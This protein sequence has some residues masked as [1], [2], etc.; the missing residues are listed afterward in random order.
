MVKNKI[1]LVPIFSE[2][3][4]GSSTDIRRFAQNSLNLEI[5]CWLREGGYVWLKATRL[6]LS[7]YIS[8]N[9]QQDIETEHA[10]S[11]KLP[12]KA[13]G[14]GKCEVRTKLSFFFCRQI[15]REVAVVAVAEPGWGS[16]S[17]NIL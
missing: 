4:W 8:Q 9:N 17:G 5:W 7:Q 2:A 11:E 14:V 6:L 16:Y 12:Y 15:V 10:K 1:V 13:G 3:L